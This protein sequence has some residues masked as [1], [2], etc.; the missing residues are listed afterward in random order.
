M[1]ERPQKRRGVS[2]REDEAVAVRPDRIGR[3]EAQEPLPE[4]VRDRRDARS[5]VPGWPELAAWIASMHS[6]RI[7]AMQRSSRSCATAV[8]VTHAPRA[9]GRRFC[10]PP[11]LDLLE[12][13]ALRLGHE[14]PDEHVGHDAQRGEDEERRRLPIA[15]TIERKNWVTRNAANQLTAVATAMARPRTAVG[16]DLGDDRPDDRAH[17]E[18][19]RRDE[20]DEREHGDDAADG[21]GLSVRVVVERHE[22]DA[23]PRRGSRPCPTR[24]GEEERPPAEPVDPRDGDE[25]R[26][27]VRHA[28]GV[29]RRLRLL[30]RRW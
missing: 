25:R 4:R 16:E 24:P 1:E 13:A 14:P 7:V 15:S 17:R 11:I 27:H 26:E 23:R 30:L 28:D 20:H 8:L 19:E 21:R 3:V 18:R 9:C 2:R 29:E 6:V 12:R 5:G 10:D 22:R